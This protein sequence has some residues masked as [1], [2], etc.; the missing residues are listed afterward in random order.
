MSALIY[1][2]HN[3]AKMIFLIGV[4]NKLR[5]HL[6]KEGASVVKNMPSNDEGKER[7]F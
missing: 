7:N 4:V 3:T 1:S 6:E 5:R 2:K